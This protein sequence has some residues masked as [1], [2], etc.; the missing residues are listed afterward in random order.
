MTYNLLFQVKRHPDL[1]IVQPTRATCIF[2]NEIIIMISYTFYGIGP[3][4]HDIVGKELCME[5]EDTDEN[6]FTMA[7]VYTKT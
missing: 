5:I 4:T 1:M 7:F 6:L 3:S 2:S